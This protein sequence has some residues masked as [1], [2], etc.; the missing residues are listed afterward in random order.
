MPKRLT[1]VNPERVLALLADRSFAYDTHGSDA[2]SVST[3]NAYY[4]WNLKNP[5]VLQIRS[6]W[7]GIA[8]TPDA[9]QQL[10][11]AISECNRNRTLPKT[12]TL[13][14]KAEGEIGLIAECNIVTHSGLTQGQFYDFCEESLSAIMSFFA[15]VE[16]KLP[17]LVTWE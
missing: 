7:R 15:E 6:Q 3:N 4:L 14:L 5:Q 9:A 1:P 2:W 12:F 10:R 16:L 17:Q 13:P 11:H 8:T